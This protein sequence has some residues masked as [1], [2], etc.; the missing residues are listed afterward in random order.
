MPESLVGLNRKHGFSHP[1]RRPRQRETGASP[2]RD[3]YMSATDRSVAASH[4]VATTT[5]RTP[6]RKRYGAMVFLALLTLAPVAG[7]APCIPG[8][9]L[10]GCARG[11]DHPGGLPVESPRPGFHPG[12]PDFH[13]D[14]CA[15]G[16][17][18][19]GTVACNAASAAAV[20]Q[21]VAGVMQMFAPPPQPPPR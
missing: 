6:K 15:P 16:V 3:R 2:E 1:S 7:A 9:A 13:G 20:V 12:M 5:R 8:V 10:P 14:R 4:T 11:A 17:S 18:V 19:R 21:G